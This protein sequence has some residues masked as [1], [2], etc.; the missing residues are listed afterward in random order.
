MSG[1]GMWWLY[2]GSAAYG[3]LHPSSLWLTMSGGGAHVTNQ[4]SNPQDRTLQVDFR[5]G[6]TNPALG[7]TD[8]ETQARFALWGLPIML[9]AGIGLG[10]W[11]GRRKKGK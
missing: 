6:E 10:F 1:L 5:F 7:Y 8:L 3:P 4:S 11:L 2:P 9:A